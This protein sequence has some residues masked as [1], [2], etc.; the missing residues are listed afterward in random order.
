MVAAAKLQNKG[1]HQLHI[2]GL[3]SARGS[4]A[5]F[6]VKVSMRIR[7][8]VY[9]WLLRSYLHESFVRFSCLFIVKRSL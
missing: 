7:K 9:N 2:R 3:E 8:F 5:R 1:I 6:W 4:G